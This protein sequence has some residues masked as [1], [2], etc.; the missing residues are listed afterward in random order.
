MRTIISLIILLGAASFLLLFPAV[1]MDS[2]GFSGVA[3]AQ[4]AWKTEFDEICGKTD[5][6]DAL[7]SEELKNLINR[8]DKLKVRI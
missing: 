6:S 1:Q 4:E 7:T 2:I 3:A 5:S 8:C